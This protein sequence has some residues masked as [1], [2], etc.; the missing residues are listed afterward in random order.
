MKKLVRLDGKEAKIGG[1]AAGLALYLQVDVTLV[2]VLFIV[3]FFVP[4]P[5]VIAYLALWIAMPK[6]KVENSHF[7]E[8]TYS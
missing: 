6:A 2:R 7:L 3:L 1:V 5:S 4:V 8:N